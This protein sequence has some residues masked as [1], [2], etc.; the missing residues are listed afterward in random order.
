MELLDALTPDLAMALFSGALPGEA[1]ISQVALVTDAVHFVGI[2]LGLDVRFV[3]A[4]LRAEDQAGGDA[5]FM[6]GMASSWTTFHLNRQ[7]NPEGRIIKFFRAEAKDDVF[8][9][10][11]WALPKPFTI[12]QFHN[13]LTQAL[14]LYIQALPDVRQFFYMPQTEALER[15]YARLERR[16][17]RP[18]PQGVVFQVIARPAVG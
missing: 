17:C 6:A 2:S 8:D 16:F 14:L 4:F 15:W 11:K 18:N 1:A 5:S 9:P 10:A 7:L 13:A 12:W 3:V